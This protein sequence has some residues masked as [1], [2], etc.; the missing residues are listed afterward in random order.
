M[1]AWVELQFFLGSFDSFSAWKYS[2]KKAEWVLCKQ[3]LFGFCLAD[4]CVWSCN[5]AEFCA[6]ELSSVFCKKHW[7][8]ILK[9]LPRFLATNFVFLLFWMSAL[10]PKVRWGWRL[11]S[12]HGNQLEL[13]LEFQEHYEHA[14]YSVAGWMSC[15]LEVSYL[16]WFH[17]LDIFLKCAVYDLV[18]KILKIYNLW[19]M[20]KCLLPRFHFFP[21]YK[22]ILKK[23]GGAGEEET[24]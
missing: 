16:T 4:C 17:L 19:K 22:I 7:F 15:K 21:T 1:L 14:E 18:V 23:G 8:I 5:K 11:H 12:S 24:K 9:N 3:P 2:A 13:C 10:S 20:G 6:G